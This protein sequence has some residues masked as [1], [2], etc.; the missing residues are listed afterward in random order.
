MTRDIFLQ[1]WQKGRH[2][3]R[4]IGRLEGIVF[5]ECSRNAKTVQKLAICVT[6]VLAERDRIKSQKII[7]PLPPSY[8]VTTRSEKTASAAASA[9]HEDPFE[10]ER[11]DRLERKLQR[12]ADFAERSKRSVDSQRNLPKNVESLRRLQRYFE[13]V[14]HCN[15]YL[16]T[17]NDENQRYVGY[18]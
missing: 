12:I 15:E 9:P 7:R 10:T 17:M 3:A 16:R 2:E 11:L 6:H 5:D 8:Y 1:T 4:S 13:K 14:D 18:F